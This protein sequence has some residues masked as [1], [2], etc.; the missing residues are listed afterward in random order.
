M[1]AYRLPVL[2]AAMVVELFDWPDFWLGVPEFTCDACPWG[3]QQDCP[4]VYDPYNT[5]GDCLEAK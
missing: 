2:R 5:G 4:S 3:A 1:T